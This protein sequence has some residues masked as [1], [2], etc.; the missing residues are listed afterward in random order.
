MKFFDAEFLRFLV[1]GAA[2][3]AL[4]YALYLLFSL[5]FDYRIAY[6]LAFALGIAL[7]YFL[8]AIF[9]FQAKVAWRSLMA[10]PSVYLVQY[11]VGL[12]LIWL[13]VAFTWVPKTFAPLVAIPFTI[14]L[15]FLASR[16]IIKG[17]RPRC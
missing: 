5:V 7:S 3:T 10:F 1:V 11:L 16:F 2:N 6:T 9:V 15:T 12:A 4:G 17:R 13:I 14:P 8:S